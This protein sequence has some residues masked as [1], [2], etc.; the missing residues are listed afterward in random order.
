MLHIKLAR[1]LKWELLPFHRTSSLMLLNP[2]NGKLV[3]FFFFNHL[4]FVKVDSTADEYVNPNDTMSESQYSI[5]EPFTLNLFI[6]GI[7]QVDVVLPDNVF[8]TLDFPMLDS[9]LLPKVTLM[10]FDTNLDLWR[11]AICPGTTPTVS[12][13]SITFEVCHFTLFIAV[14]PVAVVDR[15][16]LLEWG[17]QLICEDFI[18][19]FFV[20]IEGIKNENECKYKLL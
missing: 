17:W 2:S 3:C 15:D 13:G 19:T 16:P 20:N 12:A 14:L 11:S 6:N 1:F 8:V 5:G 4:I 10:M 18:D 7:K 9:N